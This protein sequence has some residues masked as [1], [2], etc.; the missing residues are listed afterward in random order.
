MRTPL[1]VGISAQ[2]NH[3][4]VERE[5]HT[6]RRTHSCKR[7]QEVDAFDDF[8]APQ[9]AM[10]QYAGVW[11]KKSDR[12]QDGVAIFWNTQRFALEARDHVE[13]GLKEGVGLYVCLRQQVMSL[14]HLISSSW[15]KTQDCL[16]TSGSS[17]NF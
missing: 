8:L 10:H 16:K 2:N 17:C 1:K 12:K 4:E 9:L 3:R 13:F 6:H 5:R 15:K 14:S 11:Q 7:T